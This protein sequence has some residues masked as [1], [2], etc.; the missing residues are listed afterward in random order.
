MNRYGATRSELDDLL[1][2]W[3]EPT[4]RARQVWQGFYAQRTALDH[5]SNLPRALR[6]RLATALPLAFEPVYEATA[7]DGLTT[8]W[9]W[10]AARDGVQNIEANARNRATRRTVRRRDVGTAGTIGQIPPPACAW[11]RKDPIGGGWRRTSARTRIHG[12]PAAADSFP[13]VPGA[14]V[15]PERCPRC[16]SR[17]SAESS[18]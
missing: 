10:R 9:L 8:K 5:I 3:G 4:Y 11:G 6:T 17:R 18:P 12:A 7:A 1:A 15:T 14:A 13:E 16:P 2:G